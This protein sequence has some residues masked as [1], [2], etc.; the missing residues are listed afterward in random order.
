VRI[1]TLPPGA[2]SDACPA[3]LDIEVAA[4][5]RERFPMLLPVSL[6]GLASAVPTNKIGQDEAFQLARQIFAPA[7][8]RHP[9]LIDIF[10]NSGIKHRYSVAPIE[11]FERG[12]GW[13]ERSALYLEGAAALFV[14]AARRALFKA[15]VHPRDVDIVVTISS[16]GI[17]TPSLDAR[18][19]KALG[20]RA[21]AAR[22]PVFGLGCA[23]GV[24]GLSIGSR[25]ARS[26]PGAVVLVVAVEL[27]T[28]AFRGDRGS[29]ADVVSAAL[30]GDGAA[31]AVLQAKSET[32]AF[33][34][35]GAA[36]EHTW[37]ATFDIM[38]WS[39]DPIGFGVVLSRALPRFVEERLAAPARRFAK[40]AGSKGIAQ[41][42]CHPGGAKVLAAIEMA[43]ELGAGTLAV[44]REVLC[45]FGNMSAPTALFVLERKLAKGFSGSAILSALG[46][47]FTASFVAI[48]A[49]DG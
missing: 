29:K 30:F 45:N 24:T 4:R 10:A 16:T 34:T 27:C 47:G 22:V 41:F 31:A 6:L 15:K 25:L 44:E 26:Q 37:P 48:E 49:G 11:W 2:K 38:G 7:F 39:I 36:Q 3:S 14:E 5:A 20:L 8:R 1:T 23:G 46:P 19:A 32:R 21:D 18:V 42:T 35:F 13:T 40:S 17:A 28:L 33:V 43:L 12:N 9:R